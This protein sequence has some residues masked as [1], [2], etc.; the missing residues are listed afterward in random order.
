MLPPESA[1]GE[2]EDIC[3]VKSEEPDASLIVIIP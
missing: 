1:E 3:A 2:S